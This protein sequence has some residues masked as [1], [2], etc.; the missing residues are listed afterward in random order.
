MKSVLSSVDIGK[1]FCS[2]DTTIFPMLSNVNIKIFRTYSV[3][4]VSRMVA[5]LIP[6]KD[7]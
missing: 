7:S 5:M 3:C 1:P 2:H 6:N 4:L